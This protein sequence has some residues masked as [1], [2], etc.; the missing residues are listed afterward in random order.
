MK[1]KSSISFLETKMEFAFDARLPEDYIAESSLRM[2]LYHR[3]GESSVDEETVQILAE[4]QDRFGVPPIQVI[5]LYH[6]TRI[7]IFAMQKGYTLLKFEKFTFRAEKQK[8]KEVEKQTFTMP[9]T[10][11]PAEFEKAVKALLS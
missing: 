6:L 3:L 4:M 11:D 2:E 10:N 5:W 7:R 9:K 8:G 1:K